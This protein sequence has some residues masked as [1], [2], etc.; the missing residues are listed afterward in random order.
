M[1]PYYK[2]MIDELLPQRII[3]MPLHNIWCHCQGLMWFTLQCF[4]CEWM[5]VHFINFASI[6]QFFFWQLGIRTCDTLILLHKWYNLMK[7]FE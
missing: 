6:D 1:S 2:A 4:T 5:E 7:L 3:K